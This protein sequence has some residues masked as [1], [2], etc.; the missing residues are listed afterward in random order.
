MS[1]ALI[2][3]PGALLDDVLDPRGGPSAS[4]DVDPGQAYVL[5][6]A[7]GGLVADDL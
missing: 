6:L 1:D 7:V 2:D 4:S 5:L 3:L